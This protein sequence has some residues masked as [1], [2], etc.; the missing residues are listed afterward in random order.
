VRKID[1]NNFQVA[2]CETVRDI[3]S[4]IV[5]NLI[6]KHQ[7]ISRADLSRRS[8]LQRSTVSAITEELMTLRWVTKGAIGH[9]PHGRKPTFFHLNGE[10]AS[11]IG[12]DLRPLTTTIALSGLDDR[13]LTQETFPTGRD[14]R[15]F[16]AQLGQRLH[17]LVKSHPE[18]TCEG[19]GVALPGR[20]DLLSQ[21][22]VFA[23]NLGWRDLDLKTPLE[24]ATGLPVE[25]ENDANACAL[26]AL[27]NDQYTEG[28]H[29]LLAVA[30]TEGIGVGIVL[31]GQL[32]RGPAGMAGE[33]GHVVMREDGPR[34]NCG[35]HGCWEVFA[36]NTAA[37]RYYTEASSRRPTAVSTPPTFEDVLRLAEQGDVRAGQ[38]LDRM[39]HYL[40]DGIA[41]L[42]MGLAPSIVVVFGEV[43]Q[44]WGRVGPLI[45]ARVEGRLYTPAKTRIVPMNPAAETRLH[46]AIA[47]VLQKHF[48]APS[49]A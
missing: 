11:I 47:L 16:V 4:R 8:G 15:Q 20:V 13:F 2:T 19:V 6:R 25:L 24:Q 38:A 21:R 29:N 27:W 17:D 45:R 31:N 36:S 42:V 14:P 10:R 3:N 1:L 37:V 7:P 43:T 5:L 34:C 18:I 32:V 12:V 39:A 30:I 48:G 40:G 22:L 41:M 9:L 33:F 44:A 23:P 26:A 46:G 28:V 35:N 49:I